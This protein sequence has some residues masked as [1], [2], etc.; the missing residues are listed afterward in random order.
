M[1]KPISIMGD[2]ERI[3]FYAE[4]V[5]REIRIACAQFETGNLERDTFRKGMDAGV[6]AFAKILK[7]AIQD[8]YENAT[9]SPSPSEQSKAEEHPA[10]GNGETSRDPDRSD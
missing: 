4:L 9:Q 7:A 6:N 8:D 5:R 3:D 1:A 2:P 10:E